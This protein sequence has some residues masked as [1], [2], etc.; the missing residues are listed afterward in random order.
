ML[1][2]KASSAVAAAMSQAV[3]AGNGMDGSGRVMVH[4][5]QSASREKSA[6]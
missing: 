5:A 6:K 4:P 1:M 3:P 2:E